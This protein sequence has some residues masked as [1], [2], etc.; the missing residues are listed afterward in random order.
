MI[1]D[2]CLEIK[3][4]APHGGHSSQTPDE[5]WLHSLRGS[6]R[7]QALGDLRLILLQGLCACL[8]DRYPQISVPLLE[9]IA[10]RAV[11]QV[12]AR[13]DR[14]PGGRRFISWAMKIAVR[15]ALL[16]AKQS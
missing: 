5:D 11:E 10:D 4:A 3:G 1:A 14:Y 15:T 7:S 2:T 16:E 8:Q 12:L 6:G 9:G 13:L